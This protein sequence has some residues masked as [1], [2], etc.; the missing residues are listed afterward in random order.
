MLRFAYEAHF[1]HHPDDRFWSTSPRWNCPGGSS[2]S[3]AFGLRFP[4]GEFEK[5]FRVYAN[6]YEDLAGAIGGRYGLGQSTVAGVQAAM[7]S[8][9]G[10]ARVRRRRPTRTQAAALEKALVKSWSFLRRVGREVD[11]PTYDEEVNGWLPEQAYYAVHHSMRA[12]LI[13]AGG[14]A[15]SEH[16]PV[17]NAIS[18]EV[19]GGRLIFPWSASCVGCPQLGSEAYVGLDPEGPLNPL[20][21][22][23]PDTTEERVAL[24]LKTTRRKELE[25]RFAQARR[26]NLAPG[27]TRRNLPTAEKERSAQKLSPTTLFDFFY[28]TR[29]KAHYE[30]PDLFVL[31]AADEADARS[32][33]E[34]LALVTES[35]LMALECLIAAYAGAPVLA[36]AARAYAERLE[37][38][39]GELV[40]RRA[41]VWGDAAS[42]APARVGG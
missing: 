8:H 35:S 19:S 34:S 20:T 29:K 24:L 6:Y 1:D 31:G 27:A 15:P 17:L 39:A 5:P 25:R 7:R 21:S 26:R 42:T 23:D 40:S 38:H 16:R 33:G 13:A 37:G 4:D 30:E 3:G 2:V 32:F 28:R 11:E 36:A 18:G 10:L 12:V 41:E 22:P 9:P 14:A